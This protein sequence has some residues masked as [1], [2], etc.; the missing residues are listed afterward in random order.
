MEKSLFVRACSGLQTPQTPIWL[1][2]QAGRYMPEYHRVKGKTPSLDFFKNPELSAEVTC[3]AQRILDVDAAILFADLLPILE[4]MGFKLDYFPEIGPVIENPIR[5]ISE[6]DSIKTK[7]S[8]ESMPYIRE[9]IKLI[10]SSLPA[11]IPLIG[12]GGAP[13]TLTSYAIEGGSSKSYIYVKKLMSSHPK[14][15][16]ELMDKMTDSIIDYLNY[17][18]ISGV[19][20]IQVFDSWV[21]CLGVSDYEKHVY[22]HTK[23][24]F[25]SLIKKVPIIHFGTGNPALLRLM[26]AA[27]GDVMALDWRAPLKESWNDLGCKSIQGNLD[28]VALFGS[29]KS[30]IKA[31][32]EI[33]ED[34][35]GRPGHIFN[36]GHGIL[37]Q[38]PL[39]NVKLLVRVVKDYSSEIKSRYQSL[40]Y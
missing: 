13:F 33:L 1:N 28:P 40:G 31:A 26:A 39:E 37:P 21:G 18:I 27:G 15:F 20:A 4:P 22:R 6:I 38:T 8:S 7:E 11:N 14:E 32:K 19:D 2:R 23:R 30:V 12:F 3:D 24:L 36:L 16:S 5:S 29:E 10:K 9:A 17:Q 35:A 34:V 25:E